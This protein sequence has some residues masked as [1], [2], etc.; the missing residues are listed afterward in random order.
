MTET[1]KPKLKSKTI[2]YNSAWMLIASGMLVAFADNQALI[3]Q[4]IPSWAYLIVII[5]NS[6][7]GVFL[8]TI[9]TESVAPLLRKGNLQG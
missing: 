5:V 2:R 9:T 1:L 3:Q 6:G 7:V 4:Y 8:R